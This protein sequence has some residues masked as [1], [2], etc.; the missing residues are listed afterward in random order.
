MINSSCRKIYNRARGRMISCWRM[1]L[2][3][4]PR[5]KR[6][7]I[8][9]GSGGCAPRA[10]RVPRAGPE[11][12]R[13]ARPMIKRPLYYT[14]LLHLLP[15]PLFSFIIIIDERWGINRSHL[16][17]THARAHT[18]G[19]ILHLPVLPRPR[20]T[21]INNAFLFRLIK[22]WIMDLSFTPYTHTYLPITCFNFFF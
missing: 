17:R 7:G 8:N 2:H 21:S 22:S 9:I 4:Q 14:L 12:P 13:W 20:D 16:R 6:F 19:E 11:T 5:S 1:I 15:L 10:A 3:I 18:I